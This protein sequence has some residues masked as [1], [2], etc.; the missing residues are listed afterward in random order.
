MIIETERNLSPSNITRFFPLILANLVLIT[1]TGHAQPQFTEHSI[2][3]NFNGAWNVHAADIDDDGDVDVLGSASISNSILLW[4]NDGEQNFN[5]HV[6]ASRYAEARAVSAFDVDGDG[7]LDIL[8]VAHEGDEVTWWEQIDNLDFNEHTISREV[9]GPYDIQAVDLDQDGSVDVVVA[10][11]NR[12]DIWWFENDGD[13][14]FQQHLLVDDYF[15][16]VSVDVADIDRDG[17]LDV[18]GA[19]W[20]PGIISWFEN[21]GRQD[22]DQ[23]VITEDFPRTMSVH[24]ADLDADG[25]VDILGTSR[26][27][28]TIAWWE[29]EDLRF[30]QHV[31]TNNF[32]SAWDVSTADLDS[33]GDLDVLGAASSADRI[34]W[35]ENDGEQEFVEHTIVEEYDAALSVY[36]ADMNDDGF[37]DVLTAAYNGNSI[38]WWENSGPSIILE[39]SPNA[40]DFG[41]VALETHR[42]DDFKVI[43]RSEDERPLDIVLD[44]VVTA[45]REWLTVEPEEAE[46]SALDTVDIEVGVFV[47]EG[48]QLGRHV[49]MITAVPNELEDRSIEIP[50]SI[51]VVEWFGSLG[52]TVIDAATDEPLSGVVVMLDDIPIQAVTDEQGRY[53]FEELPVWEHR[54]IVEV[55]G[56]LPY[57]S[58]LIEIRGGQRVTLDIALLHSRCQPDR[59]RIDVEMPP[60][61]VVVV[62]FLIENPGNGPLNYTIQKHIPQV[63]DIER[64]QQ[65]MRIEAAEITGD[66][67]LQGIEFAGNRFFITGGNNGEGRGLI[68]IFSRDG[69]YLESLDQFQDSPWGIRDLAWDGELLW[70]GD[71]NL[72][73]C[74]TPEGELVTRFEGPL[75]VNRGIT[76]DDELG[77]LWV[78]DITSDLFGIDREGNLL[79]RIDLS[80]DLHIYGLGTYPE[81]SDH[82]PIYGFCKDGRFD[83]QI[84]RIDP[85]RSEWQVVIDYETPEELKAG[86]MSISGCWNPVS[87]ICAGVLQGRQDVL[88][89]IVLLHLSSRTQWMDIE[90]QTGEVEVGSAAEVSVTFN[91][92]DLLT[93]ALLEGELHIEHNGRGDTEII[94]VA[95]RIV[96]DE[97]IRMRGEVTSAPSV[98]FLEPHPNPFNSAV[99]LLY[100]LPGH[101]HVSVGI[102]DLSGRLIRTLIDGEQPAGWFSISWE[103]A[104]ISSG[105]YF[106]VAETQYDRRV[107]KLVKVQ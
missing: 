25:D 5:E 102:Y 77:L 67:R 9:D 69:E 16:V 64:W 72:I 54:V 89:E 47:P 80:E 85:A 86:G 88:D 42:S 33:D 70:G 59:Q 48:E 23:Q 28:N 38:T 106:V 7:D 74:F 35:W 60:D 57:R 49:G 30:T 51:F 78:C 66:D 55:E 8:G 95:L 41:L 101:S 65:R 81:D 40:L 91:S 61:Q 62:E 19:Q 2:A 3:D 50:V 104:S 83:T 13:Q 12:A 97:S 6:I 99:R 29:N 17:D 63:E 71:E 18:A 75:E 24:L 103:D 20:L 87:W 14:N 15:N 52:G 36:A 37:L 100:G 92:E 22:F 46:M 31:I 45:G 53:L 68:H 34:A 96:D 73:Y 21:D 56:Y 1:L 44:I 27:A 84:I 94:P 98:L 10:G 76:W 82:Y 93:N 58:D 43:Y 26:E 107:R 32:E 39:A 79:E 105:V 4:E 11:F 90:P